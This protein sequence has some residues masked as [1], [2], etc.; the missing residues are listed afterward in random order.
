MVTTREEV[1]AIG[2]STPGTA[3][4]IGA[5]NGVSSCAMAR[6]GWQTIAVE[7]DPTGLVGATAIRLLA[8]ATGRHIDV[9]EGVGDRREETVKRMGPFAILGRIT[10]GIRAEVLP[11]SAQTLIAGLERSP[12]Q[13]VSFACWKS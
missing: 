9:H 11:H 6:V 2:E 8:T 1:R 13:P 10:L 3:V 5:G 12:G 4:D 7:P